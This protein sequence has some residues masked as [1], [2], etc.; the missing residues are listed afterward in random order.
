MENDE[1]PQVQP[2]KK[3][4]F[5][6]WVIV[7][8]VLFGFGFFLLPIIG[9]IAAL[10]IPTIVTSTDRVKNKT[11]LKKTYSTLQQALLMSEVINDKTF[12]SLDDVWNKAIK[13]QL[14]NL[15]D[16]GDIITL[17]DGTD[18]KLVKISSTCKRAPKTEEVSEK[19]AC[20]IITIDTNGFERGPNKTSVDSKNNIDR[21]TL[22][23]YSNT[24]NPA[25]NSI[26]YK[27]LNNLDRE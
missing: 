10:T 12:S 11:V 27:I 21:F 13:E 20:G 14:V 17:A 22:L 7:L 3:D 2:K 19:N 23:L 26:E 18:L 25:Y 1:K 9:V 24:V 8:M 5:P 16:N 4:K 15:K 6:T